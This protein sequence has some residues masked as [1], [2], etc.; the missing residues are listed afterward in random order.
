MEFTLGYFLLIFTLAFICEFI[1][2]SL[3]MGYGTILSPLLIIMGFEP[4]VA[5]P[6]ILLS[7][8]FGGFA[9][10]VFHHQFDNVSFKHDSRDLKVAFVISAFGIVATIAAALISINISKVFLKTYIG[11]LVFIMGIIILRNK[12]FHFSWKKM[13]G[14]GV[15]SAFNKG[16]SGGGFGPVVTSGQIMSGQD[17]KA[18]IG[19]TTFAEAP[20]C[21]VAFLTYLAGRTVKTFS[22]PVLEIPVSEFFKKMFS[23]EM[24]HWQLIL[25]LFLGS[26][27]VAP[28]G[29]FAT[30]LIKREWIHYI[31]GVLIIVLGICTLVKTYF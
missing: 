28:F 22:G 18:A 16:M 2:S 5:V 3:G 12:K 14:I 17:H 24:F 23:P 29:A 30:K 7:Q 11:V 21:I 13:I 25:A 19:V 10:S 6:A 20:I 26:I 4:V 27:I 8:A 9:A 15:V 1:D 31:L